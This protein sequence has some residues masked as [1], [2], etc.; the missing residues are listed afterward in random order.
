MFTRVSESG[1]GLKQSLSWFL[2]SE[3]PLFGMAKPSKK[4]QWQSYVDDALLMTGQ[5][6]QAAIH[7]VDGM[8]WASSP[9]LNVSCKARRCLAMHAIKTMVFVGS[10]LQ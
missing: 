1:W 8:R 10:G 5:V 4:A 2:A 6:T 7:G 3:E 9:D